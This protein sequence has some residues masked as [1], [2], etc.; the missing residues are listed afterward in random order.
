M[1]R[2]RVVSACIAFVLAA[3]LGSAARAAD[4]S[5]VAYVAEALDNVASIV[6]KISDQTGFGYDRNISIL[7]AYVRNGQSVSLLRWLDAGQKYGFV[8]HGDRDAVDLDIDV[9]DPS[10]NRVAFDNAPQTLALVEFMPHQSGQYTI[11]LR[12]DRCRQPWSFCAMAILRHGGW[13]V[14]VSNM[15][16]AAG[17]C[18]LQCRQI[19]QA[20]GRVRFI[21]QPNQWTLFGGVVD[22][23]NDVKLLNMQLGDGQRLFVGTADDHAQDIDLYLTPHNGQQVLAKDDAGDPTPI[24]ACRTQAQGTYDLR[25]NNARSRG[26]SL[27]FA[28]ALAN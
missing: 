19:E 18:I 2:N 16:G 21:E 20:Q 7:G 15:L 22:Q 6:R 23:G 11:V 13:D 24:F 25:L 14:P 17:R 4:N 28:A 26:A 27:M 10:G 12:L 8:G 9:F 5:P 1:F 3:S